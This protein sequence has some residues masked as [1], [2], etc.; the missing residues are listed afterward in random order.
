M[1]EIKFYALLQNLACDQDIRNA[2][3]VACNSVLSWGDYGRGRVFLEKM[4]A[5]FK[6]VRPADNDL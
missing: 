5:R 1:G 2:I 4:A 3:I 6:T